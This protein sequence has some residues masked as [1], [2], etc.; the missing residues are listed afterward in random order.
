MI[1]DNLCFFRCLSYYLFKDIYH[2]V[3]LRQVFFPN[4]KPATYKGIA[5]SDLKRIEVHYNIN[6]RVLAL[7]PKKVKTKISKKGTSCTLKCIRGSLM[8]VDQGARVMTLNLYNHHFSL[9]TDMDKY[10][11]FH[12][13]TK[14]HRL[15][16][17]EYN[18]RRHSNIKQDCTKVKF[19][20]KGGVYRNKPLFSRD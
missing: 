10:T 17:S 11:Q 3:E 9:V 14:C 6:I 12:M 20:Y 5:L 16:Q 1:K 15:F 13:G 4:E 8:E 2:S 19:I 18:L 7:I